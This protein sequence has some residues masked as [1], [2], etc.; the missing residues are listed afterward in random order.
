MYIDIIRLALKYEGKIPKC[1]DE[2][3][4]IWSYAYHRKDRYNPMARIWNDLRPLVIY[5]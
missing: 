5:L 3:Y 4:I 2:H 1:I